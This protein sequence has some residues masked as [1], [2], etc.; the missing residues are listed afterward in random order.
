MSSATK[1]A[2]IIPPVSS[3][4]S[5]DGSLDEAGMQRVIDNLIAAG[6]NGLFFLG[7]GGE[8]SQ[9]SAAERMQLAEV[10][11]RIVN[12]RVP[13]LIGVG[14]TNTREA[15]ALSQHAQLAGADAIVA[16]NPYYWQITEENV[17]GYYGAIAQ[18]VTLPIILYN[19][20]NLT[21]QDLYPDL[22][23]R[24]VDAYANIVGIKDT[25]DSV[26]H[27]RDMITIVKAAHPNFSVFCG[28]D[29]HLLN[30][31]LLGGDGA[32]SASSNFA[33]QLSV[34]LYQAVC[35]G[36]AVQA[37][38][39]HKIILQLPRLYQIDSPFVNVVKEAMC[40]C[41]LDISTTCLPPTQPLNAA[42]KAQVKQTL[43]DAGVLPGE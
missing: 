30:T 31:L 19:F 8:F 3:I 12:K 28:F 6:V 13:V 14:S 42:R 7:T 10:A 23:K 4:F 20:P 34:A 25:I 2:G 1:F 5:T 18:A 37:M 26:A 43:I 11:V 17:F 35:V 29:D 38:E 39:K 27:L 33:P 15:V 32:I 16:I 22:V 24:L 41:G 9:M 36:D 40:L 21:G